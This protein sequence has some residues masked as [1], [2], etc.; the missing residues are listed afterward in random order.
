[1]S[2]SL[3]TIYEP[4]GESYEVVLVN[5]P[6]FLYSLQAN[7]SDFLTVDPWILER[8]DFKSYDFTIQLK[9]A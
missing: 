5:G 7:G 2:V 3:P 1:M 9:D 8:S 6:D 4:N